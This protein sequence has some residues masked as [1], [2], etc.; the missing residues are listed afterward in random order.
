MPSVETDGDGVLTEWNRHAEVL[1]GW[2]RD[3]VLGR[4]VTDFLIPPRHHGAVLHDLETARNS[5]NV[6]DRTRQRQLCLLHREGHEV[7]V[8]GSAYIVGAGKPTCASAGSS[9]TT[10]RTRPPRRHWR[11]PT[12]TTR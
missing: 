11:T 1:F 5:L 9:T 4:P 6:V 10:A 7:E 12:C 2:S 3:E 8:V